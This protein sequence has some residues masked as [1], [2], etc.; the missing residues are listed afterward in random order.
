MR[1]PKEITIIDGDGTPRKFTISKMS[2]W[3]GLE[4]MERF[5][6]VVISM[7]LPKVAD[8]AIINELKMKIM[9]YVAVDLNGT[10]QPLV[11]QAF[12]DNHTGDWE[13]FLKLLREEVMYNNSFFRSGK[14]SALFEEWAKVWWEKVREILRPSSLQ[15]STPTKQNSTS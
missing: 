11:T 10:L 2:A 12:I 8:W 1:D 7:G 14:T 5:P 3:D 9:K 15:S 6:M 4:I 13:C